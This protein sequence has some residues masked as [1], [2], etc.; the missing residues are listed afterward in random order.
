[1]AKNIFPILAAAAGA[2]FLLG[3][4][5]EDAP[6]GG[7]AGTAPG[8]PGG[9]AGIASNCDA[10]KPLVV[11]VKL[12]TEG[13]VSHNHNPFGPNTTAPTPEVLAQLSGDEVEWKTSENGAGVG[14]QYGGETQDVPPTIITM[15]LHHHKIELT[16]GE[17][18]QL[19]AG[20]TV[21][22]ET[23]AGISASGGLRHTHKVELRCTFKGAPAGTQFA[24]TI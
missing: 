18:S 23:S 3:R 2:F 12:Y 4:K 17:I 10:K 6:E 22:T 7:G 13:G 24:T 14:G 8:G 15:P 9:L 20:K 16:S 19:L 5:G 1:M 21:K 11:T